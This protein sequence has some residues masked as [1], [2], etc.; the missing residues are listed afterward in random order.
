[1]LD[2]QWVPSDP[3][4]FITWGGD[5][6]HYSVLDNDQVLLSTLTEP[7]TKCV[8]VWGGPGVVLAAGQATGRVSFVSFQEG[9]GRHLLSRELPARVTRQVRKM[10]TRMMM[11]MMTMMMMMITIQITIVL[12]AME[13]KMMMLIKG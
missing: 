9:E 13:I 6:R 1:M 10:M 7:L 3:T 11:M 2:V 12:M 4:Q 5:I 8:A